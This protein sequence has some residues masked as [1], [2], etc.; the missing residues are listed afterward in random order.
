MASQPRQ[1]SGSEPHMTNVPSDLN[2]GSVIELIE[3]GAYPRDVVLTIARGFLPLAQEELVAVLAW[4]TA[5]PDAEIAEASRASIAEL[6][7]RVVLTFASSE[8]SNAD[9]LS[10]L[11]LASHDQTVV[12]ALIR[13]KTIPDSAVLDLARHAEPAIQEV[14]VINQARI[15]RTPEI[16]DALLENPTLSIDVRRRALETRE[17]FFDKKARLLRVEL[18]PDL[19]IEPDLV[20]APLDEI[21]DLLEKAEEPEFQ[22]TS[23]PELN[24]EE[25]KVAEWVKI[26]NMSVAQKVVIAFRGDKS[27]RMLLVRERNRLVAGSVMRNPR[28]SEQEA[29]I[30]A[31][32]RNVDEEVLRL[33]SLRR[34]WMTKYP[35]VLALCRNP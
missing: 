31:G 32:M 13:N 11:L 19:P 18:P 16:L 34:D 3:S 24:S 9:Y 23:A 1:F 25:K 17:E 14:I 22:Q 33:L 5:Y 4:L 20:D 26:L 12:E 10:R 30:I 6:P 8:E 28:M 27:V 35:V 21:A 2:S 7:P 15:L 29:E